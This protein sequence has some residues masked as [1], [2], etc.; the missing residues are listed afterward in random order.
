MLVVQAKRSER[1]RHKLLS[2]VGTDYCRPPEF[3]QAGF[4]CVSQLDCEPTKI[5]MLSWAFPKRGGR[6]GFVMSKDP[7][8][9]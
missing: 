3:A 5:M 7:Y 6:L 8:G 4:G 1:K 2:R 9:V